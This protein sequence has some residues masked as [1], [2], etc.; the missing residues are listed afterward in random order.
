[1]GK[2]KLQVVLSLLSIY[3]NFSWLLYM[4]RQDHEQTAFH[5]FGNVKWRRLT[6]FQTAKNLT[7]AF[8]QDQ[9]G[10]PLSNR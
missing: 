1:M 4:H 10:W 3:L 2:V 8:A 7:V 5:D 6:S 9:E